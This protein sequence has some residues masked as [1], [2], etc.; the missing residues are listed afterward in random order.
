M[1]DFG[2]FWK[3]QLVELRPA[4]V[5]DSDFR[6]LAEALGSC[7]M[8]CESRWKSQNRKIVPLFLLMSKNL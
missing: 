2:R 4:S 5:E 8:R 3:S 1:E 7:R 6:L